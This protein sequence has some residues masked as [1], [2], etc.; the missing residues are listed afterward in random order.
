MDVCRYN[1]ND[2][3]F[4]VDRLTSY[5]FCGKKRQINAPAPPSW[6]SNGGQAGMACPTGSSVTHGRRSGMIL[7]TS[8]MTLASTITPAARTIP[9]ATPW[10]RELSAHLRTCL[11]NT[12]ESNGS[13]NCR[14][15]IRYK[16]TC[17]P[18]G[19]WLQ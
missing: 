3:V 19:N 4:I 15:C 18:R 12:R 1:N 7:S 9:Q 6:Q 2:F 10:Q 17:F 13:S 14:D 11:K 16:F 5:I 8:S